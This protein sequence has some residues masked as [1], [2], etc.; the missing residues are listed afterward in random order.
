MMQTEQLLLTVLLDLLLLP[1]EQAGRGVFK[2][3]LIGVQGREKKP[4]VKC[5]F[6]YQLFCHSVF[7][8]SG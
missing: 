2:L 4:H 6:L 8:S 7:I 3:R 5:H 1:A